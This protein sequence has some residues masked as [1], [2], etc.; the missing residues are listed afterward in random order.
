MFASNPFCLSSKIR[1]GDALRKL[2]T[3]SLA[4]LTFVAALFAVPTPV[5]AAT[6]VFTASLDGPSEFPPNASPG[7][8]F[9]TVVI[10]D[11]P[12]LETL[13][14]SATFADLLSPTTVAHIH[15]CV[16]P[17]AVPP[18]VGVATFPGTFPGFPVGVMSGVYDSPVIDMTLAT[19]YTAAFLA[20][21][22]G[23]A[24]GAFA[25]LIAGLFAG[26]AYFNIHTSQFPAGEIRGFLE[27]VPIPSALPLFVTALG[28]MCLLGWGR[29]RRAGA[30]GV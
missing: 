29:K 22:G 21:N 17:V 1:T 24:A 9:A 11:T 23:T 20:A 7:T 8:G 13:T 6:L 10:D 3:A 2:R 30:L 12:G 4:T 28:L 18:T 15:C 26:E 5:G 14:V 16:S 25:G 19:S 27:A